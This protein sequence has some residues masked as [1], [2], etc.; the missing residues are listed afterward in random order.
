MSRVYK[1]IKKDIQ[2]TGRGNIPLVASRRFLCFNLILDILLLSFSLSQ[3]LMNT[4]RLNIP[5]VARRR[6]LCFN[7]IF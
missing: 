1:D 2:N 4:G 3:E 6:F 5:V 7:L